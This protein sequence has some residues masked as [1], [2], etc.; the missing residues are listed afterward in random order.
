MQFELKKVVEQHNC[1]SKDDTTE[2]TRLDLCSWR[3]LPEDKRQ[4]EMR[5]PT[6]EL[7]RI[8][9]NTERQHFR[10]QDEHLAE[11]LRDNKLEENKR[12]I[13]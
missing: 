12:R 10:M 1:S 13:L 4:G 3:G 9:Q 11:P 2:M 7:C 5:R 6:A 8:P